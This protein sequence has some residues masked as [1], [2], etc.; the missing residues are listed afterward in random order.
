V[1]LIIVLLIGKTLLSL[2]CLYAACSF[3]FTQFNARSPFKKV[4]FNLLILICSIPLIYAVYTDTNLNSKLAKLDVG[5]AFSITWATSI[6]L[7]TAGLW[8]FQINKKN[9]KR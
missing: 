6:I 8:R 5:L 3:L 4:V 9:S 1:I 7:V 2:G